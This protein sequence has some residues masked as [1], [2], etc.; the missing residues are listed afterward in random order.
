MVMLL[1]MDIDD[2]E[3]AASNLW[4]FIGSAPLMILGSFLV[5]FVLTKIL[6]SQKIYEVVVNTF[7]GSKLKQARRL[8]E[9]LS[10]TEAEFT[11]IPST[12]GER[13]DPEDKEIL[14]AAQRHYR[15]RMRELYH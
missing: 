7:Q 11:L 3:R 14:E 1:L 13:M 8:R 5:G 4:D 15:R 10:L 12:D 6:A 2:L 9:E